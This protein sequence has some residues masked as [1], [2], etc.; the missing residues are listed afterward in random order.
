MSWTFR[1]AKLL[2][3]SDGHQIELK[4]GTWAE[5]FDIQPKIARGTPAVETA[6]LIREGMSYASTN[7]SRPQMSS[8]HS[9]KVE[10]AKAY[11]DRSDKPRV[12]A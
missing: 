6:R 10:A 8:Q 12:P 3:H 7:S 11:L 5:P 4:A 1:K 2:V 9:P